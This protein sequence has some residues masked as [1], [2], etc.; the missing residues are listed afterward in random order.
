MCLDFGDYLLCEFVGTGFGVGFAVDADDGFGVALAEVYPA[1]FEVDFHSVDGAHLAVLVGAVFGGH[2]L[3]QSVDVHVGCEVLAVFADDVVGVGL[4]EFAHFHAFLG[5]EGEEEGHAYEGVA[6]VVEFGVDDASVAFAADDGVGLAHEGGDVYFAYGGGRILASGVFAGDVAQGAGG[7]HVGD[8]VAR[9][10]GED[11]V[12]HADEGVFFAEHFAGFAHEGEAVDVGV[13]H[14]AEVAAFF[15]HGFGYLGEVLRDGLGVVGEMAGGFA[16][17]FDHVVHAQGAEESGDGYSACGVD[18]VDS[19]AEVGLC[20]G[21]TVDQGQGEDALD[22]VV[23]GV[24]I[25]GHLA[26]VV[27]FGIAVVFAFG[28]TDHLVAFGCVDEF[29]TGVEQFEGVPVLGVVRSGDDDASVGVFVDDAHFGGGGG[30]EAC[31]DNI[32]AHALQGSDHETV[33]HGARETGITSDNE[34]ETFGVV[35][36][37]L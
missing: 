14:D 1:V 4:A 7:G 5:Q 12:G 6:T 34:G 17:E 30:A 35:V 9:G 11:V 13:D 36:T 8:G 29:A 19:H 2:F 16:V 25:F 26:E 32:D 28:D 22:V 23:D 3:Q 21:F 10:V 15:G 37:T 18:C 33:D 24:E 20:D 31:F 27:D